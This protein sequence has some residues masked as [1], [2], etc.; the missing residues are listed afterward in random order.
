MYAL[1]VFLELRVQVDG[2]IFVMCDSDHQIH[3][4]D[5]DI[6]DTSLACPITSLHTS[7][8]HI[9]P[10]GPPSTPIAVM[11]LRGI[12][13]IRFFEVGQMVWPGG[14]EVIVSLQPVWAMDQ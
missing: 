4:S 6:L 14:S 10:K 2:I 9:G 1:T 7:D 12:S 5:D 13:V 11:S 8:D 3:T